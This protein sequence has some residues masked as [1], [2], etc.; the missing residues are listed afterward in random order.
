MFPLEL[1]DGVFSL[2]P[3]MFRNCLTFYASLGKNGSLEDFEVKVHRVKCIRMTYDDVDASLSSPDTHAT[4]A[5]VQ[6]SLQVLTARSTRRIYRFLLRMS[7]CFVTSCALQ[8]RMEHQLNPPKHETCDPSNQS[9]SKQFSL[10][11][12]AM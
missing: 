12:V 2:S 8:P 3:E 9:T 10:P 6:K 11:S 5:Q 7:S 1:S 4:D